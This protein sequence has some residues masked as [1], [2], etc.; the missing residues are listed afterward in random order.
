[1]RVILV[2]CVAGLVAAFVWLAFFDAG[3]R[4]AAAGSYEAA[5]FAGSGAGG[6][7]EALATRS[8]VIPGVQWLDGDQAAFAAEEASR[9]TSAALVARERSRTEFENLGA[10]QAAQVAREAFPMVVEQRAGGTPSLSA[11][12]RLVRYIGPNAAQI[13]LPGQ[14][15]AVVESMGAMANETSPG[16]FT[17]IDLG[18][19]D[20]GSA[21]VPVSSNAAVEIPKRLRAYP[22]RVM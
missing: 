17:P 21:Y 4:V 2:A 8:L 14:K 18:L 11:G 6:A 22:G 19:R 13:V 3:A 5:G 20:A 10:T 7:A 15:H 9:W 16:H 12:A 1:V